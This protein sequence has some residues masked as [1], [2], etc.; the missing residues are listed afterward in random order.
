M[1]RVVDCADNFTCKQG[2]SGWGSSKELSLPTSLL[3]ACDGRCRLPSDLPWW[4]I[5]V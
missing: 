3:R 5:S 4:H 1:I 2:D